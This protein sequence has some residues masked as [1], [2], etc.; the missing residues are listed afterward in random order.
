M[1]RSKSEIREARDEALYATFKTV[2]RENP[3]LSYDEAVRKTMETRQPHMWVSFYGVYR[4]LLR[5]K[6]GMNGRK[7]PNAHLA[8]AHLEEEVERKYR[9]LSSSGFMK[10]ASAFFLAS[11]IIAEPSK[12]FY[13]SYIYAKKIISQRRKMHQRRWRR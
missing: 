7:K 13:L 2:L 8:K 1:K 3:E 4:T 6:K 11:F 5:I 9:K 12:G 10:D